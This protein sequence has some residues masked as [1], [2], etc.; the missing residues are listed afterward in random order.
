MSSVLKEIKIDSKLLKHINKL[1]KSHKTTENE[2]LESALEK[3]LEIMELN[4]IYDCDAFEK[5]LDEAREEIKAGDG[6]RMSV[7]EMAKHLG[8]DPL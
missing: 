8:V 4:E 1:A 5:G 3:G 7:E 2:I 6:V